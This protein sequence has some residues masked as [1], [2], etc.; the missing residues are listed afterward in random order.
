MNPND[1]CLLESLDEAS[2]VEALRQRY[3]NS[4]IYTHSGL[5]LVSINPYKQVPLY[6]EEVAEEYRKGRTAEPHVYGVLE[7]CLQDRAI[8]G[9]HTIIISGD[10]GAGKTACAGCML[11]YLGVPAVRDADFV[12][13]SLGNCK[14]Q[15]NDNSSRF[16]KL[17]RLN[18]SVRIE[19][20][21][22]ERSRVTRVPAGE[23][24][25]HVFYYLLGRRGEELVNDYIDTRGQNEGEMKAAYERLREA[26]G[27]LGTEIDELEEALLGVIYLGSIA[28]E[29][30]SD[31]TTPS[32]NKVIKDKNYH[33]AV[34]L[35]HLNEPAFEDFLLRKRIKAGSDVIVKPLKQHESYMIRDFLARLIY[36]NIFH[37]VLEKINKSLAGI[38]TGVSKL[39][40]LDIFGFE[41]N[42]TNGL[43]QFCI[44]WCNE[45]IHDQ[46]VRDTFEYQRDILVAEGVDEKTIQ[47]LKDIETH[48]SACLGRIEAKVGM[49]DLISEESMINGTAENLAQ[50]LRNYAKAKITPGNFL[51]LDHFNGQISYTLEDFVEKNREKFSFDISVPLFERCPEFLS[52]RLVKCEDVVGTFRGSLDSLFS[53]V[54]K[55]RVKY[56]KCIK[57]NARKAPLEFEGALVAHQL[58]SGGILE[59]IRLGKCLFPH[60]MSYEAFKLRYPFM[61]TDKSVDDITPPN[62]VRG[63]TR[64]FMRDTDLV[65]LENQRQKYLDAQDEAIRGL[66]I[67]IL[68]ERV[69]SEIVRA[70][71]PMSNV[72]VSRMR[73]GEEKCMR[74]LEGLEKEVLQDYKAVREAVRSA[75]D[76]NHERLNESHG[77][78]SECPPARDHSCCDHSLHDCCQISYME[79]ENKS[80]KRIIQDL[81][82]ELKIIK[83]VK[84]SAKGIN[85]QIFH[86]KYPLKCGG[87]LEL[88]QEKFQVLAFSN[89]GDV[90]LF[91]VFKSLIELFL[92]NL[93]AYSD[94]PYTKDE[95]VCFAQCVYYMVC[96]SFQHTTQ[97][98]FDVFIDELNKQAPLFQEGLGSLLFILSN[99]AELRG[100]FKA[101]RVSLHTAGEAYQMGSAD[102]DVNNNMISDPV[103]NNIISDIGSTDDASGTY[104]NTEITFLNYVLNEL[105]V[106][107]KNLLEQFSALLTETLSDVLPQ[108]I[109]DYEPLKELNTKRRVF[110]RW[111]SGTS[112]TKAVQYLEH[113]NSLCCFYHL[114]QCLTE[115][116][117][118]YALTT[119]DQTTFNSLMRRRKFLTFE[120]C[121]EIKYN[122]AEIEKFC[123]NI[124]FKAGFAC[125][126]HINEAAKIASAISRL[127]FFTNKHKTEEYLVEFEAV[128][129]IVEGSFLSRAQLSAISGKFVE[130]LF[131]LRE[132]G[133]ALIS[134]ARLSCP[135]LEEL[136]SEC[137]FVEPGYLPQRSL[138]KILQYFYDS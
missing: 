74:V 16:G 109:L 6:T 10:S 106:S 82:N 46:F 30:A 24:N 114:P 61:D 49:A 4:K 15:L 108:A 55:T 80:L 95:I 91:G 54:K 103:N 116:I 31:E 77:C 48:R 128:R 111:F 79:A 11:E 122:I 100:L 87:D 78:P 81:K 138:S 76:D 8:Y 14:T 135:D 56:I 84:I 101:R 71:R 7:Q 110:K 137:K 121:Y 35:L 130:P 38:S 42:A 66:A 119:V 53:I 136:I 32:S 25:F 132:T 2:L 33:T 129:K 89:T 34:A 127:E 44:N 59:S 64:V 93:P 63:K 51:V 13:E 105:D 73:T 3:V 102:V 124:G 104:F 20:Y 90:S 112:I 113:F 133:S 19:T 23:G 92:D 27:R 69:V 9:E 12:L 40:I 26:M 94:R 97:G 29:A 18:G 65:N 22:L 86:S 57:P 5:F 62:V 83:H 98:C 117:L 99:L 45:R 52:R 58:R 134:R 39:N 96:S 43:N 75:V 17:I 47:G 68:L 107:I 85:S 126:K 125:L 70:G 36:E 118:S 123:F 50:K 131:Q 60:A 21:L 88:L 67:T 41:K 120:K 115:A 72:V 28:V 1:L 37:Y